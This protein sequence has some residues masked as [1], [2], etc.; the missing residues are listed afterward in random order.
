MKRIL[1]LRGGALGDLIV[2][3]PALAALRQRWPDAHLELVGNAVAG[4]LAR[5]GGLVDLVR[6]Q[7]DREWAALYSAAPLPTGLA[8]RLAQF[9]LVLSFWPDPDG[10]LARRFPLRPGQVYLSAPAAPATAP[11][12]AHYCEPLASLGLVPSGHW[13]PLGSSRPG[14]DLLAIH[15]GSGSP[16]KNWPLRC[17]QELAAILHGRFPGRLRVI[18]GPAERSGGC[19]NVGETWA[20]LPLPE[21]LARLRGCRLFVGHDSGVSHLA[22]AAGVPSVLLFGPT[23]PA[24]W[25]P[26]APFVQVLRRGARLDAISV[27]EVSAAIDATLASFPPVPA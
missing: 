1:V 21:L 8:G 17:W 6:S 14:A 19:G 18:T 5:D 25:A 20:D 27:A 23:D 24:I 26:P 13:H 10:D 3:L 22:A 15:P 16:A 4:V 7:H 11:A 2:T 12:A 9:D